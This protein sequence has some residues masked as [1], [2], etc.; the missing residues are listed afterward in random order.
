MGSAMGEPS[1]LWICQPQGKPP[2]NS[3]CMSSPVKT[4]I[5]PGTAN[6][7]ALSMPPM[8]AWAWGDRTITA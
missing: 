5:T 1:L 3:G 6:A 7:G 8:V 4:A 2:A